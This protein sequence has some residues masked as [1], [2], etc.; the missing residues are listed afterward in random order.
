MNKAM[1]TNKA[2]KLSLAQLQRYNEWIT[3]YV[4]RLRQEREDVPFAEVEM[5]FTL[6]NIGRGVIARIPGTDHQIVIEKL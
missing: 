2:F 3:E 1:L 4:S 5:V 6:T